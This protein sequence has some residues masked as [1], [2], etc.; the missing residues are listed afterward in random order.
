[1]QQR[2]GWAVAIVSVR[3]RV[4]GQLSRSGKGTPFLQGWSGVWGGDPTTPSNLRG[5]PR[6][7]RPRVLGGVRGAS[8][9]SGG[10]GRLRLGVVLGRRPSLAGSAPCPRPPF[11]RQAR[12]GSARPAPRL[13]GPPA[14]RGAVGLPRQP[15]AP[16]RSAGPQSRRRRTAPAQRG[17]LRGPTL[18]VLLPQR[19]V[20]AAERRRLQPPHPAGYPP[21]PLPQRHGS[22]TLCSNSRPCLGFGPA[23]TRFCHCS[24]LSDPSKPPFP[25]GQS[26]PLPLQSV[27]SLLKTSQVP[28]IPEVRHPE[29]NNHASLQSR[30]PHHLINA[31]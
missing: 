26:L 5:Q 31:S 29:S 9:G 22:P 6:A 1:M 17:G 10:G 2:A 27:S 21:P 8:P 25:R 7:H 4:E 11:P 14:P 24:Q 19:R 3:A 16:L 30:D 15:R 28:L 13:P 12:P 18:P 20:S 23:T